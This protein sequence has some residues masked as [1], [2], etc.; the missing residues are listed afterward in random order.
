MPLPI[1]PVLSCFLVGLAAL[2]WLAP[3]V[4]AATADE[5]VLEIE[6]TSPGSG[7]HRLLETESRR[8][9]AR[10]VE[11]FRVELDG[12]V[13]IRW[14]TDADELGRAG[15]EHP[16]A[17]AGLA[18]PTRGRILLFAPALA[19]HP[20][21]V[22][23]VLLHEF[24]HL[25][26]AEATAGAEVEPP[27]WLNEG[28]ATWLSGDWDLGLAYRGDQTRLLVDASAAGSLLSFRQL[29]AHFPSGPFFRL[30]YAQ[31]RSFVEWLVEREGERGLH[32]YLDL[33]DRDLDPEPA[34]R[35]VWRM[36]LDEAESRWQRE[37][38]GPAG[39]RRL[40]SGRAMVGFASVM[41]LVL[42]LIRWVRVRRQLRDAVDEEPPPPGPPAAGPGSAG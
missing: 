34:F 35:K 39:L 16:G 19:P 1:R 41:G 26:F 32:R 18:E 38:G 33:L 12:P 11:W 4:C 27:K 28:L 25:V 9:Y 37:L 13:T 15:T 10:S 31:S 17:I 42:V 5:L 8:A 21:R 30:A 40:P 7:F 20:E 6:G 24:S 14:V 2:A 22:P 23:A 29:D 3:P 36:T